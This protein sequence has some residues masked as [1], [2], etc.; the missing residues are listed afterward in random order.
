MKS[1]AGGI[2]KSIDLLTSNSVRS[3]VIALT[4]VCIAGAV[5]GYCR[6]RTKEPD[7]PRLL[8]YL[9][10]LPEPPTLDENGFIVSFSNPAEMRRQ[11]GF[12]EGLTLENVPASMMDG[13]LEAVGP[14]GICADMDV[15]F[16]TSHAQMDI[17][18][19]VLAVERCI[20]G[21]GVTLLEGDFDSQRIAASLENLGY[22]VDEYKGGDTSL[23]IWIF[24]CFLVRHFISEFLH[25]FWDL[26]VDAD[27]IFAFAAFYPLII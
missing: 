2:G 10:P 13:F 5:A 11:H 7:L 1:A 21:G 19:D 23:H 9:P 22:D 15:Y 6:S 26:F 8:A 18:Y 16:Q 25:I 27:T 3:L 12:D 24:A 4:L 17:G 20:E 14:A